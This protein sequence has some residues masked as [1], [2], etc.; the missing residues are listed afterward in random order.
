MEKELKEGEYYW[1]RTSKQSPFFVGKLVGNMF[2]STSGAWYEKHQTAEYI[3]I[4][5]PEHKKPIK[6]YKIVEKNF[7]EIVKVR[8]NS[9]MV[10]FGIGEAIQTKGFNGTI[11]SFKI[12]NESL[13][14]F[15][16]VT[17]NA[18]P[19]GSIQSVLLKNA[20]KNLI[21]SIKKV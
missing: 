15:F 6:E 20:S 21:N 14:I 8:R 9:D 16:N 1:I 17:G 4:P 12:V 3:H 13:V 7:G 19:G 5:R 2:H 10:M 11:T 18:W